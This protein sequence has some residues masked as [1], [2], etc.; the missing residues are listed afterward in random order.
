[1]ALQPVVKRSVSADVFEQIADDVLS[2]ELAPG[3]ALP[4]ERQ[5]AEALGV[6]RPAVREALQRL[7]AAGLVAVRQGDATTVLDY[8]RGAGLEVLPRLLV[9]A[10]ALD[11]AV[12]RSILEARLHNGPKVAELAAARIAEEDATELA[13]TLT[14]L[15]DSISESESDPIAQ[16]RIALEFW[17]HLV[18]AADSIVFRLMNNMLRAAYEPALAALAPIMSAE[19]G[20][21]AGYRELADAVV[22]GRPQQAA[23][24]ARA[25]LEP[26][27]TALISVLDGHRA[28]PRESS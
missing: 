7:S 17:D 8:R 21:V 9:R 1:M 14:G 13:K 19:V 26:A 24:R 25:L 27:T 6:S 22:A 10:G 3:T 16:Q 18:D 2:G 12:A 28:L 15:V 11:P 20:N 5:L 23:E 4:S